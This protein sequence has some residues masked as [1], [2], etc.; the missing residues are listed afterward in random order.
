MRYVI[1]FCSSGIQGPLGLTIPSNRIVGH[2]LGPVSSA[3]IY[4][5]RLDGSILLIKYFG[6]FTSSAALVVK[7]YNQFHFTD[8]GKKRHIIL[9]AVAAMTKYHR[10]NALNVRNSFSHTSGS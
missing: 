9:F 6:P 8:R 10:L 3:Q 7:E 2:N 1:F 4:T 5:G